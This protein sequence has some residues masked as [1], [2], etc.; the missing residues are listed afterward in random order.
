MQAEQR[1]LQTEI[2]ALFESEQG[3]QP[4]FQ[5]GPRMRDLRWEMNARWKGWLLAWVRRRWSVSG[6]GSGSGVCFLA[7]H[8][9][10]VARRQTSAS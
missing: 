5:R 1:W 8:T 10:H 3:A 4:V 9:G 7:W 6:C 2:Q